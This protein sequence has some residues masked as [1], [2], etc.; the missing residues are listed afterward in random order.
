MVQ[1]VMSDESLAKIM[2]P[3]ALF[4]QAQSH[5]L[6][7]EHDFLSAQRINLLQILTSIRLLAQIELVQEF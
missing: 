4:L 7:I 1:N 2:C 3:H 5:I 6:Q